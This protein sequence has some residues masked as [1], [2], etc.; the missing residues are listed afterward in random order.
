MATLLLLPGLLCDAT[1]WRAVIDRLSPHMRVAV[2][3]FPTQDS[4]TVMAQDMLAAHPGPL[5]VAGHSMG[6]RVAM[7]MARIAPDR[8]LRLALL[9]TGIHP[10]RDAELPKRQEMIDLAHRDG[11]AA[12]ARV[13]LP[14]MVHP[15]RHGDAALMGALTDM[16]LRMDPQLHERQIRALV[17]RPDA[18]QTIGAYTGPMAL[19]VGR[20]DAWSPVSQHED[21]AR[22]CP[23]ARLTI[24][25]DA[26]HFAPVERP[27]PVA[28]AL[29]DWALAPEETA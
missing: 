18:S 23:Q 28:E 12:L 16:V 17:N 7:E 22:L 10:R 25:E 27:G 24:I 8:V 2:G 6:G 4:L 9:D 15:D 13:W 5:F 3:D 19:I 20:Q 29:A 26:G 1:V 14:P 21:I 11:M